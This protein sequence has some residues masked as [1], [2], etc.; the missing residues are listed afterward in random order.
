LGCVGWG[1]ELDIPYIERYFMVSLLL[2]VIAMMV[3]S[4]VF[5]RIG[6]LYIDI[7]LEIKYY[8]NPYYELGLSFRE[9]STED[10]DYIE[11]EFIIGLFFINFVFT[12]YKEIDA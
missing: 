3:I 2:F 10:P 11:Q 1:S 12:F 9:H 6:S 8:S 4:L 5:G 7:S